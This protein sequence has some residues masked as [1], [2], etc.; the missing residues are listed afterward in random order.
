MPSLEGDN[1]ADGGHGGRFT[2][3]NGDNV[4]FVPSCV[5]FSVP[6]VPSNGSYLR[7]AEKNFTTTGHDSCAAFRLAPPAPAWLPMNPWPA[8]S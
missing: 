4:S 3:R 5:I 7:C 1:G 2:R 6:P 8:P